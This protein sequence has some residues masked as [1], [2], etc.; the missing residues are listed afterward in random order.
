MQAIWRVHSAD[1]RRA[2]ALARHLGLHPITA[3]LLLN[4]GVTDG[5]HG[6]RFLE[7]VLETLDDPFLLPEMHNNPQI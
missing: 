3:Q 7:P 5:A 4:R 2:A 1:P 6:S